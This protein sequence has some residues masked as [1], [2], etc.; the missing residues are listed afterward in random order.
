MWSYSLWLTEVPFVGLRPNVG[1]YE[2]QSSV[3]DC[4]SEILNDLTK[5]MQVCLLRFLLQICPHW[6]FLKAGTLEQ[7]ILHW[8]N[9]LMCILSV[10]NSAHVLVTVPKSSHMWAILIP[11]A[12]FLVDL[13]ALSFP[14]IAVSIFALLASCHKKNGFFQA[15][16]QREPNSPC[17]QGK[18]LK[19]YTSS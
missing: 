15:G 2:W 1:L 4:S 16:T 9:W 17:I 5:V 11:R 19:F 3:A 6:L 7:S 18:Y 14:F 13:L 8:K 10:L 12:F